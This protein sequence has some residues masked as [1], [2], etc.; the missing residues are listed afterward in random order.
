LISVV[1]MLI[2]IVAD[3]A[4]AQDTE[5][6]RAVRPQLDGAP[7]P[8]APASITRDSLGRATVRAIRLTEP[9]RLDGVLDEAIYGDN[10]PFGDFVAVTPVAGRPSSER[11]DVWVAFDDEN[12]YVT[13]RC[14]ESAPPEEW[15]VNE[16]RR[17]TPGLRN[18]EH[19]GVMF[20]T[21][22]DRRS[23]MMFYANP[24]G[25]RSDYSVV[26]EGS[27]NTDWNP[28]WDVRSG[29]FEGGW[30][31]E[32]AIPFKSLRYRAG[33]D[34][35][36]GIQMRRSIRHKNEWT[37]LNPVPA[38]L[39]GPQALN[40]ISAGGTLVGLDLPPAGN[41]LELKPYGI[42]GLSTNH[43]VDP[44]V[45]NDGTAD[46]GLD[47]KY[48]LTANLTADVTLN[49]DFAQVEVDE[50]Q[51]NLTRFSLFFPEKRDFFLENRGV[52]DFGRGIPVFGGGG[53][54]DGGRRGGGG[55]FGGG[56][57]APQLFYSRRIG[58]DRD[59][60]VPIQAGARITGK[61]GK[62][63]IGALNIQT[64][65]VASAGIQETNYSVFR[66]KRDV[67]RRSSIGAIFTNRS[68]A[69]ESPGSNR[70][71]GADL[72]F[73]FGEG[74]TGSAYL[75]RTETEG[76]T[77][78][79]RSW[80]AKVDYNGDLIGANLEALEVGGDFNPEIGFVRRSG[81]R[82][83]SGSARYSPR[84]TSIESIRKLTW[85]VTVD[86]FEDEA[87]RME[88]RDQ[89]ARFNVELE[90]SDQITLQA[91]RKFERLVDPFDVTSDLEIVPGSYAYNDF[92]AF[93]TFGPQRR[94]SGSL[95]LNWGD[96]FDGSIASIGINQGRLVVTDRL[97]LEPGISLNFIDLPQGSSDQAVGRLRADYGFTPRMFASALMQYNSADRTFS[98][99]LR[100]RWEYRPGSE[101]FI[102]WTDE[103]DT[104]RGGSGLRSRALALKVTRLLRF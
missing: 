11:T 59:E 68:V 45:D 22:Y 26:D 34:Q 103:R 47:F 44:G 40:R 85:Q 55:V 104:T 62:Y 37:Y 33:Q 94:L 39:A 80:Q 63:A 65:G 79:D 96:F 56:G 74:L 38:V 78:D 98:S 3:S 21:F 84:P 93:V 15:I 72:A 14:W 76:L 36:W 69:V 25:G 71:Y 66:V 31:I 81:F 4:G 82:K 70:A 95:S 23:G 5:A 20:D 86:Y 6:R 51:V 90:S 64:D 1:L 18:N 58:L 48:G 101:L 8:I 73:G 52:F 46:L 13:C 41:N 92:R 16:L 10:Q 19:F 53:G 97:S 60:V 43:L 67:L 24:I 32:M 91:N 28:V 54:G 89:E 75:A 88:S 83:S 30:T 77:G 49:T 27:P 9:L 2:L 102:V 35:M 7:P 29:R 61:V 99:N 12:I 50:Q 42:A 87:G 57:D 17:D 100:F